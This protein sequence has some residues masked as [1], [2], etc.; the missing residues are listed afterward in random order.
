M[1]MNDGTP[2]TGKPK[3]Y[4]AF[5]FLSDAATQKEGAYI[6]NVVIK[7][8]LQGRRATPTGCRR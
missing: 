1:T 5:L 4:F 7:K 8:M 6:D 3:V 2:V